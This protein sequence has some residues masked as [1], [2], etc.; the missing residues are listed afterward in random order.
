MLASPKTVSCNF[1]SVPLKSH[2]SFPKS[3]LSFPNSPILS[4]AKSIWSCGASKVSQFL[5]KQR[6]GGIRFHQSSINSRNAQ[7][8]SSISPGEGE[9]EVRSGGGGDGG[10]GRDWTTSFLLLTFWLGLM[11]YVFFLAPN[12]TPVCLQDVYWIK[13]YIRSTFVG[14]CELAS[15][16]GQNFVGNGHVFLEKISECDWR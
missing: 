2:S 6:R 1:P 12:Q 15:N 5:V 3:S 16:F 14:N 13:F 9:S 11:Y 7:E 10:E 4:S 8:S